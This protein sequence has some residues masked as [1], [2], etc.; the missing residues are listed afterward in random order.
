M[1]EFQR[2]YDLTDHAA[3]VTALALSPDGGHLAVATA[4]GILHLWKTKNGSL[5]GR[6]RGDTQILS[7]CWILSL[8]DTF[9]CGTESGNVV[10]Y[11][12]SEASNA[13][14][15]LGFLAHRYPVDCMASN[16]ELVVTGAGEELRVWEWRVDKPWVVVSDIPER[17][18]LDGEEGTEV[19]VT[20]VA[21]ASNDEGRRVLLVAY[22]RHGLRLFDATTWSCIRTIPVDGAI[23]RASISNDHKFISVSNL[24]VGFEIYSIRSG[25]LA[26]S[27]DVT[28]MKRAVPAVFSNDDRYLVCGSEIGEVVVWDVF[29]GSKIQTLLHHRHDKVL[30]IDVSGPG[31]GRSHVIAA[32]VFDELQPYVAVWSRDALIPNEEAPQ[33]FGDNALVWALVLVGGLTL[34]AMFSST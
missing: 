28:N 1:S 15:L 20:S 4:D 2:L 30:S 23:L 27:F 25:Q 6:S 3:G 16:A 5:V 10:T 22:L 24:G 34:S 12:F 18:S 32:G 7:I 8:P 33:H 26:R 31:S 13:L 29:S 21:W 14:N 17:P 9:I 19:L 11:T